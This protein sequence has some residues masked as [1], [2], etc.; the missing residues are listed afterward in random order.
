MP[1][2]EEIIEEFQKREKIVR[3]EEERE[4]K[5]FDEQKQRVVTPREISGQIR[6]TVHEGKI[7]LNFGNLTEQETK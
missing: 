4:R 1:T 3:E 5:A 7:L 2:K 6:R